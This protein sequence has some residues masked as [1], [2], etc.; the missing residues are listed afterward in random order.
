MTPYVRRMEFIIGP[1]R[2]YP[3]NCSIA[4]FGGETYVNIIRNIREPE[5]ERRFYSRLVE[6]GVPVLIESNS[7]DSRQREQNAGRS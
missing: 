4:S 6:L 3:N 5:L 7:R 2:T 1:Q